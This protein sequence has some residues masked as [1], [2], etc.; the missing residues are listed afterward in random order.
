MHRIDRPLKFSGFEAG[1]D[2]VGIEAATRGGNTLTDTTTTTGYT[3]VNLK[4]DVEDQAPKFGLSP[5][6]EYRMARERLEG[7]ESAVSYLRLAPNFRMPFGHTHKEQEEI[8]VLVGGSAKIKLD[9]EVVELATWDA[10]RMAPEVMRCL[11]AGPDG[12]E[13]LMVGAPK[14][15]PQDAEMEQNWWTD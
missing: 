1:S 9:D 8:Y 6:M 13:V 7:E 5:N 14:I 10:V 2:R 11:E 3:K 12:A 15:T 4:D